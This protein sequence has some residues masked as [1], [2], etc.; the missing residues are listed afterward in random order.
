M[1]MPQRD[2]GSSGRPGQKGQ[3][4]GERACLRKSAADRVTGFSV[5]VE[6]CAMPDSSLSQQPSALASEMRACTGLFTEKTFDWDA[7]PPAADSPT[8]CGPN[9]AM[10]APADRP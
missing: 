8:C 7:F 9:C 10:S 1:A 6:E 3:G 2:G 4:A 5:K